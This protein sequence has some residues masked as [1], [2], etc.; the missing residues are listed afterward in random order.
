EENV[1][2][3]LVHTLQK[4]MKTV[5]TAES[6]TGGK[7]ASRI[8]SVAGASQVFELGM[9]TYSD[10]QKVE[11]LDVDQDTLEEHT[12]VSAQVAAQMARNVR[13]KAESDY[14]VST[15][16]YAGPG[17]SDVGLVYIGVS[18][19]DKIYVVKHHFAGSRETIINLASQ[20]ALDLLRRV[21]FGL[22]IANAMEFANE[23]VKP[24]A[25]GKGVFKTIVIMLLLAVV[26]A[27]GYLFVKNGFSFPN[28]S[29]LNTFIS[30]PQTV[31]EVIQQ[32]QSMN[33]FSQGF[34]QET[35]LVMSGSW[36]QNQKL[37][38]W[39]TIKDIPAEYAFGKKRH[40][41]AGSGSVVYKD[42]AIAGM[43][44]LSGFDQNTLYK[45]ENLSNISGTTKMVVFDTKNN[46]D[47]YSM[48]AVV[49]YTQQEFGGLLKM[50]DANDIVDE[51]LRKTQVAFN[52]SDVTGY[53]EI[54]ILKQTDENG[55]YTLYFTRKGDITLSQDSE[56]DSEIEIGE[57]DESGEEADSSS[58]SDSD[59]D[60][61]NSDSDSSSE[62]DSDSDSSSSDSTKPTP[63]P[64]AKP[65]AKPTATPKPTAEPTPQPT[66]EPTPEPTPQPT[67]EPTPQPTQ[68][69]AISGK[70]LTVTAD[71]QVVTGPAEEILAKI[72]SREM[73]GTWD[74]DALK[75]Q[76]IASHTYLVYQY[77][78]GNSAPAVSFK[79]VYP[80]VAAAVSEVSNLIMT[81][82]GQA[83]YTPYFASSA[84]RT[85]SSAEVW[86]GHYSHLVSVESKYDYQAGGYQGTVTISKDQMA[87]VI[88]DVIGV[89]PSGEPSEWIKVLDKT[90]GGYNNNMSVCGATTYYNRALKKTSNITGRWMRE[91]ILKGVGSGNLRSAAF[92]INFDGANF[93]FTTYGYGHG[94]G[95]SQW[96]AQ[97]YA[98]N[99]GWSYEQILKHYYQ[100]VTITSY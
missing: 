15:T 66:A 72:V 47:T 13:R 95:M 58:A 50:S 23:A 39:I 29:F 31:G 53:D 11:A 81:V 65:T 5:A 16:G 94:A 96:G 82:N 85:N 77:N 14:G 45:K 60:E 75:A 20:Y 55:D 69:P 90:S 76:A 86:G 9:C 100:G 25:K 51:A 88:R 40:S 80:Q 27:F 35:S 21:M 48:F 2:T 4:T 28:V 19:K 49:N 67:P 12:A 74:A 1:E 62:A 6:C 17:G 54:I 79:T 22:P 92:D 36:A 46:Y 78:H 26:I 8:T 63:T 44:T 3:V 73:T 87:Q 42:E 43:T 24:K 61:S 56:L 64:T 93:V 89:E 84:G 99:E 98:I 70:T 41:E 97:L 10:K 52:Q 18:T 33:F 30:T 38:S 91:D 32:R 7:I 37:E 57:D 34:E 71:G 83:A 68:P 59:S